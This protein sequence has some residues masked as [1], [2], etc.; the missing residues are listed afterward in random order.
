MFADVI[1]PLKLPGTLTYHVPEGMSAQEG[2][3]VQVPVG[4]KA[5]MGI[6]LHLHDKKPE[7]DF[8]IK[9]II[10]CPDTEPVPTKGKKKSAYPT[11]EGRGGVCTPL[12]L[13]LWQ[14]MADYY[15]CPIGDVMR[16]ALPAKIKTAVRR[17]STKPLV[18]DE[19]HD[20]PILTTAQQA[21]ID[22]IVSVPVDSANNPSPSRITLLHGVTASGKTAIYEHLIAKLMVHPTVGEEQKGTAQILYLVP[23]IALTT[24][25]ETRLRAVFGNRIGVFHSKMTD[26]QRAEVWERQLSDNPYHIILG[27]RSS[28]FLPFRNL[29]LIIVDEEHEPSYKQQEPA[30]RYHARNVALM[31]ARM[32]DAQV[33]LGSATP[34]MESYYH[35]RLGHYRLTTI[36]DRFMPPHSQQSCQT[37]L[38]P[39]PA[40]STQVLIVDTAEL[41]RK[42]QMRGIISPTLR[43]A[44]AETLDRK[45][46]IILFQNRRGWAPVIEC[47]DCGWVPRCTRCDMSLTM[48]RRT[49]VMVC[50][51]CGATYNMPARCP[52]CEGKDL[53]SHGVGTEKVEDEV[54]H[55]FPEARV[56]RLD[57][58]SAK[59]S[60]DFASIVDDFENGNSDILIGTQMVTKGLDFANVSVVGILAADTALN[61][62]DFRAYERAYELMA[63]VAGRAG[64]QG[65]HSTVVIQT[66]QPDLS[67][68]QHVVAGNYLAHYKEV[69]FERIEFCYPP[70]CR[71]IDVYFRHRYENVAEE[72]SHHFVANLQAAINTGTFIKDC[73]SSPSHCGE[74]QSAIEILGPDAPA[75]ARISGLY[76][77]K[78]VIKIRP[79]ANLKT[80]KDFLRTL[81]WHYSQASQWHQPSIVF[82]VDPMN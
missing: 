47:K 81:F 78:A 48:H 23:E 16:C 52:K 61:V 75:I 72:V 69:M 73:N 74:S 36:A 26:A 58:D 8:T 43:D 9:D 20:L 2:C 45:E 80:F 57:L 18:W 30:P 51:T 55:L 70:F 71:L 62:P 64:R 3:R 5:Y 66:R 46:Q 32:A 13:R 39:R 34:S 10:S 60:G 24:Q 67:V 49:N 27:A 19:P 35:A 38:S 50:H 76:I 65:Q 59:T 11:C 14:W 44:M 63:Q 56:S 54:R 1:L 22:S 40:I 12:M 4:T 77:R 29:R 42:K 17:K 68:V 21:A 25:L 53:R 33:V 7:G 31:L 79:E 28:V 37:P 82:D 15:L 41:R 6:V